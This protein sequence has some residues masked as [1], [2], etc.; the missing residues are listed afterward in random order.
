LLDEL[1]GGEAREIEC[2]GEDDGG[3]KA[4]VPNQSMRCALGGEAERSRFRAKD[5]AWGWIEGEGGGTSPVF[6]AMLDGERMMA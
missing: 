6:A 5:S 4:T 3:L 1:F 2:E